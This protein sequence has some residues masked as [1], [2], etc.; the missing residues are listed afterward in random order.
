[1]LG[2]CPTCFASPPPPFQVIKAIK[3]KPH[4]RR[5]VLS[6]WNPA[7][8]PQMA[9]PPCHMFAQFYVANG[10]LS[11]QARAGAGGEGARFGRG[12]GKGWRL[13]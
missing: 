2:A 9:L 3:E 4:D 13:A 12:G 11:C 6:A 8:I 7:D 5:I 10:E 1:M